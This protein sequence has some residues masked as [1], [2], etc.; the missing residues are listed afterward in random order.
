[1]MNPDLAWNKWALLKS[2]AFAPIHSV[3]ECFDA[4]HFPTLQQLNQLLISQQTN[5][6]VASG[7]RLRF[8]DQEY[9]KLM[10]EAQYEPRCYLKGE[11]PTR[12]NNWH[13]LFNALV[14]LKF[15]HSKAAINSRHYR[16]LTQFA[17]SPKVG[18]RGTV[19]DAITLLDESGIIVPY[20]EEVLA[21]LLRGF[22]W[23]EL[24]WNRRT[25]VESH[26]GFYL[27]GH[28]LYEKALKPYVGMTGHGLL[29]KVEPSFFTRSL[30]QRIV[31]LDEL[32]S[33]Y[34]NDLQHCNNPQELSP[35]PLLGIPG[36]T[37]D[38][39]HPAY[40][41]NTHYFRGGRDGKR[42]AK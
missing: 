5:I 31:H 37:D 24:F 2:S 40:Y 13:D 30:A 17:H 20:A 35:V 16:S 33:N 10:F 11:V 42:K 28:G 7:E 9:G 23:K 8:V 3:I 19:R 29:L 6:T 38:N 18:E 12:T 34:L 15:P 14:W 4:D 27:Y 32:F 25:Q 39:T 41:D 1:M 21:D 22:Q 26:M 36:W